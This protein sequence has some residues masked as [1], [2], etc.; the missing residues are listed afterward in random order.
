MQT[1]VINLKDEWCRDPNSF[2]YIG[3]QRSPK[4]W[5][6]GYSLPR[7]SWHNP[8]RV[9]KD[10]TYEE[11]LEACEK[12]ERYLVEERPDLMAQLPDVKGKTLAC[13]CK[14]GPCHGDV[15]AR[16]AE[17]L[18][19]EHTRTHAMEGGEVRLTSR[20]G[21]RRGSGVSA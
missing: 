17:D 8:F 7:S 20:Q 19:E 4:M 9:P 11:V 16:L 2:V 18:L 15:I 3:R 21:Q 14:P 5:R 1:R 6:G 13:W 12:F 10:A